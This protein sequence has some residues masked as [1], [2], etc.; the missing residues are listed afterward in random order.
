MTRPLE[1]LDQGIQALRDDLLRPSGPAISTMR[2]YN[3]AILC[4]PP[5]LELELRTR[6]RELGGLLRA[7]GRDVLPINL[8]RLFH[9][10]IRQLGQESITAITKREQELFA[11]DPA[12]AL[13]HLRERLARLVEGPSGIA[14]DVIR[15]IDTHVNEFP[16]RAAR[17][18][19]FIGR[20]GSVYPFYRSSALLKHID[21]RTRNLP[22]VLLYPGVREGQTALRF[23]G[24]LPSDRDY[25]PRIYPDLDLGA[26]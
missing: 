2:N 22:T 16:G 25:R 17:T 26:T 8:Q 13:N 20:A 23:M 7:E 24:E 3:F 18:V 21:G 19:V 6:M 5:E 4:Y 10:R 11:K 9:A 1:R 14:S 15:L 12:R